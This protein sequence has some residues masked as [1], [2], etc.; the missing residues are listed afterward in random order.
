[1]QNL[2]YF[3]DKELKLWQIRSVKFAV[4]RVTFEHIIVQSENKT[5]YDTCPNLTSY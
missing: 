1:M 4:Y 3:A 5:S 2:K